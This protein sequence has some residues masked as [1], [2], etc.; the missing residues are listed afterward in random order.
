MDKL[1][2]SL[3]NDSFPP[4]IDGVAN[5]TL[6]YARI[7]NER[8]GQAQV[9]TPRYPDIV[10]D[11]S[12]D[13]IRYA[14]AHIAKNYLT[15]R[16]GNPF[17][18]IA[19]AKISS[20]R[21]DIIHTHCPFVSTLLARTV[22]MQTNTPIV[23]TYHTKFDIDIDKITANDSLRRASVKLIVN[24]IN[25][26]DAVWVVSKGAGENLRSLGYEGDYTVVE[27]GVDYERRIPDADRAA[28]LRAK[29]GISDNETVFLFVGRMMWY[30]GVKLSFDALAAAKA[31]GK[32]FRFVLVGDGTDLEEMK[33]YADETGI[34]E[35]CIFTGAIHD[36]ELLRDYFSMCDLFLFPSDFDTNGI[37]VREAAACYRASLL[38]EGSCAAEGIADGDTGIVVGRDPSEMTNAVIAAC[39]DRQKLWDIG[40]RAAEKIYISWD[41]A[42]ER[43]YNRY[44][45]VAESYRS[46]GKSI[47]TTLND[48]LHTAVERIVDDV[49]LAREWLKLRL[50]SDRKPW[51]WRHFDR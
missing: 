22:R 40:E 32:N 23:F 18:P 39:D 33:K 36:R 42:V 46:K 27:N 9:A 31:A 51:E 20:F 1:K 24:N 44:F 12:F 2:V 45:E 49:E 5:V 3:M 35:M 37:V 48:D 43:A 13:V 19:L 10:D 29:H 30:K 25:A 26:C 21:P 41:D 50:P 16:T 11:Y 34:G 15:Y 7:I 14:S 8:L 17:D 4:T 47:E 38:L 6:N 28:A